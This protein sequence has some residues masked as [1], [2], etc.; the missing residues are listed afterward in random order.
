MY[1]CLTKTYYIFEIGNK[2]TGSVPSSLCRLGLNEE[3]F[4]GMTY[5][6]QDG[7]RDGCNSIVCPVN[8]ASVSGYFPC[9][10]CGDQG[11]DWYLGHDDRCLHLNEEILLDT[12]Y[13]KTGG[14]FWK[15]GSGWTITDVNHCLYSRVECNESGHVIAINLTDNGLYGIIPQ[16]FGM[17]RYLQSIDLSNNQ[18][19]GHLP[20]DFRFLPLEYLDVSGNQIEGIV[21]PMLCLTGDINGNGIN[22]DFSCD[23]VACPSGTWSEIGRASPFTFQ[24]GRKRKQEYTCQPCKKSHTF[25][26]SKTCGGAFLLGPGN[27]HNFIPGWIHLR[28]GELAALI[29]LPLVAGCALVAFIT[30]I[31]LRRRRNS[32]PQL[33]AAS[34]SP[35]KKSLD[36]KPTV[37]QSSRTEMTSY[38]IST[39]SG[40]MDFNYQSDH[41]EGDVLVR[42]I[43]TGLPYRKELHKTDSLKALT[44]TQGDDDFEYAP[45]PEIDQSSHIGSFVESGDERSV[46]GS[47]RSCRSNRSNRS[48]GTSS[49]ASQAA[50]VWLDVPDPE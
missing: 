21:P 37:A 48:R 24:E 38:D 47:T 17:F 41:D 32:D 9:V 7:A 26:G 40:L 13:E 46:A 11:Y 23:F 36:S 18:L 16:E 43:G 12:I 15:E 14:P 4:A 31:I 5:G 33:P 10:K 1:N 27:E 42:D 8:T 28:G 34:A 29:T 35:E 39:R 2:L 20:S 44:P 22:G 19:G 25:L 6:N 3:L 49:R 45:Q 50:E 30:A